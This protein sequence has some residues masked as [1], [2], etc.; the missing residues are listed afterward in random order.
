MFLPDLGGYNFPTLNEIKPPHDH[1]PTGTSS[2]TTTESPANGMGVAG[3]TAPIGI[4]IEDF[5]RVK[6]SEVGLMW[7]VGYVGGLTIKAM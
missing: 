6:A 4:Y 3:I 5:G 7:F 1:F 2:T